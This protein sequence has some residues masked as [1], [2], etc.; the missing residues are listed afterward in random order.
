MSCVIMAQPSKQVC[1]ILLR[2]T[3]ALIYLIFYFYTPKDDI[4]NL[5]NFDI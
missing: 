2:F 5:Q 3:L 4:Q 1:R